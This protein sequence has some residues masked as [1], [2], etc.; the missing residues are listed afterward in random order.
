MVVRFEVLNEG[1]QYNNAS[2]NH[3]NFGTFYRCILKTVVLRRWGKMG[4]WSSE[5]TQCQHFFRTAHHKLSGNL[6]RKWRLLSLVQVCL[7]TMIILTQ[8]C[9]SEHVVI[10]ICRNVG[11]FLINCSTDQS[12]FIWLKL[13]LSYFI[14]L[15]ILQPIRGHIRERKIS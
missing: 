3:S 2:E 9:Y 13:Y 12:V 4:R 15:I 10:E 7:Y 14:D 6:E 5:E 11:N 8:V 1:I